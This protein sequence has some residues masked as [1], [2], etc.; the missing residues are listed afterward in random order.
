MRK[1]EVC[2]QKDESWKALILQQKEITEKL[3]RE[4]VRLKSE[5]IVVENEALHDEITK[6]K[7][8]LTEADQQ[9]LLLSD[10]NKRLKDS[11]YEQIYNEKI[12]ILNAVSNKIDVYFHSSVNGELNRLKMFERDSEFRINNIVNIL[13][14]NRIDSQDEIFSKIDD[15]REL[16][17]NKL[18]EARRNYAEQEGAYSK[19]HQDQYQK[20]HEESLSQEEMKRALKKNNIE[21]LIGL[22]I[23]NKLGI[24]LLI[25]GVIALTQFTYLRLP[26]IMKTVLVFLGGAVLL[27][28]GEIIN[29]KKPN[30]FSLGLTSGGVAVSYVGIG[31]SYFGLKNISMYLALILCIVITGLSFYLSQRYES[32]TIAAFSIVGGYMPILSIAA[33]DILV[34]SAMA[35]FIILNLLLLVIAF[36]RKWSIA[37]FIGFAFNVFGTAYIMDLNLNLFGSRP[38]YIGAKDLITVLYILIAFLIY[39]LIPIAGTYFDKKKMSMADVALLSMNT[40]ISAIF[41]YIAFYQTAFVDYKGILA[42]LFAGTYY[43]LSKFTSKRLPEEKRVQALFSIT[44]F[45]FVVLLIP[46]Q[47]DIIWVSLGW[48]I[49]AVLF[50]VYGILKDDKKFRKYGYIVYSLCLTAFYLFDVF[51]RI[52]DE[53]QNFNYKYMCIT[54]GSIII[55]SAY[56]YK[57]TLVSKTINTLKYYTY[58]NLWLFISYMIGVELTNVLEPLYVNSSISVSYLLQALS[59][60][61][62]FI[63]AYTV[64]RIKLIYDNSMRLIAMIIYGVSIFWM[65]VLNTVSS[66]V[67]TDDITL[68]V[69]IIST[70][71]II[72]INLLSVL[73][74]MDF[75]KGLVLERKL[76][77]EWYP[78]IVSIYFVVILT[79]NL[80]IQY[81]LDFTNFIIS[82]IY[83]LLAFSWIIF[84]FIKKYSFVRRFGLGLSFLAMAK[85]FLLDLSILSE[86]YR[87]ISYFAFGIVLI[88]IS[89]VYQYFSKR[90]EGYVIN[91]S[92]QEE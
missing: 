15:L 17:A 34:Y 72:I 2:M 1:W 66:P 12:A 13:K 92:D 10:E 89:F 71:I 81:E 59:I 26:D 23:I 69:T 14:Q 25:I 82:I 45:T 44:S 28:L 64:P 63:L 35:Y 31:V 4:I 37:A 76:G 84:G 49:E 20:L 36:R 16:L 29:R 27:V 74:M 75:V 68:T 33:D 70:A 52:I 54:L 18:T 78:L 73:A 48:L 88:A 46:L 24:L 85:L 41:M 43:F 67:A 32:Q 61:C 42:V 56:L 39:T 57:K 40:Y 60:S 8:R 65:M 11:L 91:E 83:I 6:C 77:I 87:I 50:I 21:S 22:N 86:G 19:N 79:Q 80:I 55:M 5:D 51:F 62:G 47:F 9:V 3:E 53:N 38:D 58:V 30:V 90:L 7:A